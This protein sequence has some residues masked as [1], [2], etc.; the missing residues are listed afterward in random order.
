MG[1]HEKPAKKLARIPTYYVTDTVQED[2]GD[3]N[4]RILNYERVNGQLVLQFECIVAST[5]LVTVSK[6]LAEI[7]SSICD[8]EHARLPG[9][10]VH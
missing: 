3:G 10:K 4:V 5:K 6:K 1:I 9:M 2:A 7:A 8:C